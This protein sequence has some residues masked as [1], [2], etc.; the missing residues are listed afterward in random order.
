MGLVDLVVESDLQAYDLQALIPIVEAAGGVITRW[1]GNPCD[2]G[3]AV[4]ACGDRALHPR[5]LAALR[6]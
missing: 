5:A 3:G 4:V 6:S 1:D 2:E